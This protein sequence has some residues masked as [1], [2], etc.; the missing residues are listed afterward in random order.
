LIFQNKSSILAE[1]KNRNVMKNLLKA[2]AKFQ[3][4]VPV[5]HKGTKGFGYS[6]ADLPAIF[7]VINPLMQKNKLGFTQLLGDGN[8]KT[9]IFHTESGEML[10]S[11]VTIP[12]N[13]VLKGMNEFQ[14]TGSAITYY[15]RY[16]LS[17][18][19]GLVTDKDTDGS[20]SKQEASKPAPKP[21]TKP[22]PKKEALTQNHKQWPVVF[23]AVQEGTANVT[24][25]KKKF[26]ITKAIEDILEEAHEVALENMAKKSN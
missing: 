23:K 26:T 19:L 21:A 16:S 14:V 9:I 2:L 6:Y 15:R 12:N 3:Q 5:I 13:V 18:I 17:A 10:E 24:Y 7:E 4:E 22:T 8:I 1:Q 20:G 25:V 11:E